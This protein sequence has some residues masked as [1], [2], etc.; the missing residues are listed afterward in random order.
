MDAAVSKRAF[1]ARLVRRSLAEFTD[2]HCP[3]LAASI[4][5]HVLFSI[6]PLA[7]VTAGVTGLVLHATGSQTD[8]VDSIVGNIPLSAD[9]R[10]QLRRLLLGATGNL[11]A[12]GLAG[13]AGL[14]YS[15][16]GMMAA[17]R[18]ALNEAWD[19]TD[20]RPFL[21]GKL[22]DLGLVFVVALLSLA[23]LGLTILLHVVGGGGWFAF[24]YV[25]PLVLG[26]AV[27]L[28]LYRVVPASEVR[29]ADAWPAALFVAVAFMV[30]ENLFAF[31]VG[32]FANYNAVYGSLGAVIGFMFFV[33]LTSQLFLLGAEAASEWP[34]VRLELAQGSVGSGSR[35]P[36]GQQARAALL[37][38][39]ARPRAEEPDSAAAFPDTVAGEPTTRGESDADADRPGGDGDRGDADGDGGRP[40]GRA[41]HHGHGRGERR[42]V[43]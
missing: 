6:F 18:T 4:S 10:D 35:A 38:L 40:G 23:S 27:V 33:Y 25:V 36:L 14:V 7:I 28:F 41:A 24:S 39:W 16:S 12:L 30:V 15:A 8:T 29:I 32:H 34:R 31:Y 1:G 42:G 2:D 13:V 19:V 11:S 3:Q 26:F 9:G 5:Y 20:Q 43:A 21:R 37:G 17:L 22:V